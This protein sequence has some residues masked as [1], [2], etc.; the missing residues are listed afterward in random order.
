MQLARL[1]G[2]ELK[3]LLEESPGELRDLLDEIHPQ[4]IAD[5]LD[6]L[7]DDRAQELLNQLPTEYAAQV[8]ERLDEHQQESLAELMGVE[9]A[10]KIAVEMDVDDLADFVDDLPRDFSVPL[11]SRIEQLDPE[12]AEDVEE[13]R[14]WPETSAG[15]LMTTEY[16]AVAP[17]LSIQQAIGEIRKNAEDAE[18]IDSIYVIDNKERVQGYLR[19]QDILLAQPEAPVEAV[20]RHNLISVPPATDQEDVAKTLAKYDLVTLPVV[21]EDGEILGVITSD[22]VMDVMTE[23][24]SEDVHKLGAIEPL[25]EGYFDTS[26]FMFIRKRAPWLLVLFVGGFFTASAMEYYDS[27][28]AS[29]A[30]LSFYVPMLIS[31][32]GNSGSQSSTLIIR[33][34]AVGDI[35]P[36]DW[37]RVL[38][39][40]LIQGLVLGTLLAGCGV[41]RVMFTPDIPEQGQFATLVFI[42]IV[43]IV[44]M[45]CVVGGMMP[46]LLNRL[47]L[48]P[49][50]SSTPFIATLVDVL[51]I[52]IYLGLA[53]VILSSLLPAAAGP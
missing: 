40:E 28:L 8:F 15:G 45:G 25:K 31:A 16:I 27:V 10:A 1:I 36:G 3:A 23:E 2:P 17:R 50:T 38:V 32:G 47:G 41:A 33:G 9:S 13:L 26:L 19:I 35:G 5:I 43:S 18:V 48:D 6:D 53:Q 39:R 51:G 12:A 11:L 34:L 37:W 22:D 42:T 24:Q 7:D 30:Q 29:I 14:Q 4:D 44:I 49:A 20:M 21:A 46:L 52:V